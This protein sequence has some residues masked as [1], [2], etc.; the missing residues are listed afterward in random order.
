MMSNILECSIAVCTEVHF[1]W[2]LVLDKQY[3]DHQAVY[4]DQSHFHHAFFHIKIIWFVLR[5]ICVRHKQME[6]AFWIRIVCLQ[7]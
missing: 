3:L 2:N 5:L 1:S 7:Q 6:T 4:T